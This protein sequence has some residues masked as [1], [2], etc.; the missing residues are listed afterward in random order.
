[1]VNVIL[2]YI[3]KLFYIKLGVTRRA[4]PGPMRLL[5]GHPYNQTE[6]LEGGKKKKLKKNQKKRN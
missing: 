1:M 5:T 2:S 3:D 6:D 4:A